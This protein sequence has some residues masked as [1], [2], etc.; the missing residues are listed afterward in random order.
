MPS[1]AITL[2]R[3][4]LG[5]LFLLLASLIVPARSEVL[6]KRPASADGGPTVV[7]V[8]I[9]LID[10]DGVDNADQTFTANL[11][12]DM[13]WS[14]PRLAHGQDGSIVRPLGDVWNPRL[15]IANQ[16]RLIKT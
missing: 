13:R 2:S 1:H 12:L 15:Q 9:F 14:D 4:K 11:S 10:L 16:Q 5:I 8:S 6:F 3:R 7:A